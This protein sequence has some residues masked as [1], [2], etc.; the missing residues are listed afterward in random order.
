MSGEWVIILKRM[1]SVKRA[2]ARALAS[3]R[4][5][6]RNGIL[7]G[8]AVCPTKRM[9]SPTIGEKR[10]QVGTELVE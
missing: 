3:R 5:E 10:G 2:S 7:L 4:D 9:P 8:G 6:C 1:I